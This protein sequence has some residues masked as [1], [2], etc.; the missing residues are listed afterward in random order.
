MVAY[1]PVMLGPVPVDFILFALVLAG[2]AFFQ[3]HTLQ[4]A[5]TGLAAV[6][7]YKVAFSGFHQGQGFEWL[8]G[9]LSHESVV[10]SNLFLLLM[11]FSLLSHHFEESHLPLE[12][13]KVLPDDWRGGFMLLAMVFVIS[14][15]LDNIAAALIGGT[16]ARVVYRGKLHIGYLAA[17]VAARAAWWAIPPR[18]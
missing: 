3:R 14:S 2:I 18:R 12:L 17:I 10:L 5:L 9:M 16:M 11:G 8:A 15:F 1:Q 7:F 4:V 6:T 13:P